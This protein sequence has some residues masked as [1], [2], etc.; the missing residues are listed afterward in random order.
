M[1]GC[2]QAFKVHK[3]LDLYGSQAI[4]YHNKT[5]IEVDAKEGRDAMYI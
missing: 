4:N 3:I 2:L 5:V 1:F